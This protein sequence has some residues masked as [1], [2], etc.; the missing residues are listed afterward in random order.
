M[1]RRVQRSTNVSAVSRVLIAMD[2]SHASR[3]AFDYARAFYSRWG[4]AVDIL[5]FW[6]VGD[7]AR[8]V[9]GVPS[10]DVLRELEQFS[11]TAAW[12]VLDDLNARSA[13]GELHVRGYL[14]PHPQGQTLTEIAWAR[15]YDVVMG[16]AAR[17]S[18]ADTFRVHDGREVD[19]AATRMR[20]MVAVVAPLG[21]ETAGV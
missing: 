11:E 14:I 21:A 10:S 20:P 3:V 2:L 19:A 13:A 16:V 4:A 9:P 15:D 18:F 7:Y 8:S 6:S 1:V 5:Y 17:W 12:D